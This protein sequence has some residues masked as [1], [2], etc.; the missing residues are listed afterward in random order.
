MYAEAIGALACLFC[1]GELRPETPQPEIIDGALVCAAC[2]GR[3][4]V[5]RGIADFLGAP[6]P[7]TPAQRVNEWRSAAWAYE[8]MWRPFSLTL[9]SGERFTYRRELPLVTGL[10]LA[11]RGGIALDIACSNGLYARALTRSMQAAGAG[12]HAIGID[13]SLAMLEEAVLRARA[14]GLPI[15]YIRARAQQLPIRPGA[16]SAVT[17]GGSLNEIGDRAL[18][19]SEASRA[20]KR[21]GRFVAMSLLRA[22]SWPGQAL[23]RALAPGGVVFLDA[24]ELD[25]EL[26]LAGMV[27]LSRSIHRIVLFTAAE[28]S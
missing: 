19:L 27:P 20:L 22:R 4:A 24:A 21:G 13:H 15:S 5:R 12:G 18:A 28:K 14:A 6:L 25:A 3:V 17:I 2:G 23:Q 10:A 11:E 26:A 9:L 8:R 16:A 1:G 7:A